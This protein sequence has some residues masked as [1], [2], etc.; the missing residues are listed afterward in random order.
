MRH[1]AARAMSVFVL[2]FLIQWWAMAVYGLWTFIDPA[3]VPATIYHL[4][5]TFSN[6][7]G[8]LNSLVYI[9]IKRRLHT[10]KPPT[11]ISRQNCNGQESVP[12]S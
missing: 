12:G 1:A 6:I 5:T 3:A 9:Y 11:D 7:G 4:V 8:L 10:F 2:V